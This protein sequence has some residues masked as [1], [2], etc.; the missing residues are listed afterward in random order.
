[1]VVTMLRKLPADTARSRLLARS[2]WAAVSLT[3]RRIN[4]ARRRPNKK[5]R[6][7]II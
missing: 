7:M 5:L 3:A 1:M 6:A 4:V 2:S